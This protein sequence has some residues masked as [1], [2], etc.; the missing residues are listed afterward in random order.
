LTHIVFMRGLEKPLWFLHGVEEA[1]QLVARVA[2]RLGVDCIIGESNL[3]THFD[4]DWM[5][6]YSGSALTGAGLSLAGG[7]SH[8]CIPAAY[9]YRTPV[10]TGTTPLVDER[11]STEHLTVVHDGAELTRAEKVARILEWDAPLVLDHLR[12]CVMNRGGA[13][14]CCRCTKCV[15]TM[16]SLKILGALDRATTFP[17]RSMS[18]WERVASHDTLIYLEENLQLARTADTDPAFRAWLE[19]VVARRKRKDASREFLL[20]SPLHGLVP[21]IQAIRRR[22][23]GAK[24]E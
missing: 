12:V 21:M 6:L 13:Y 15:R 3:R 7:F 24:E 18:H 16:I 19:R 10:A 23:W 5:N 9:S 2:A 4:A 8:F 20:N 11:Y 17:N 14:N 1:E 22:L